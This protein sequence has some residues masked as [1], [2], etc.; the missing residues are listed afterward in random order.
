MRA[1]EQ[2]E[3]EGASADTE[4]AQPVTAR[5]SKAHQA[6]RRGL[7]EPAPLKAPGQVRGRPF[8]IELKRGWRKKREV[9]ECGMAGDRRM[10]IP[11]LL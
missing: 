1:Q 11:E 6:K 8:R 3:K 9:R 7:R 5:K 4:A 2:A 10:P